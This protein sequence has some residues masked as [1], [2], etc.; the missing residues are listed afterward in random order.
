MLLPC[1]RDSHPGETE[2]AI[3]VPQ[4]L[5]EGEQG[6]GSQLRAIAEVLQIVE[7]VYFIA[8]W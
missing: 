3:R 6:L 2:M 7:R 5:P 4:L 8:K 1:S